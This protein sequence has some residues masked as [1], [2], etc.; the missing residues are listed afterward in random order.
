[1]GQQTS[2]AANPHQFDTPL[3]LDSL[4]ETSLHSEAQRPLPSHWS[5]GRAAG[6]GRVLFWTFLLPNDPTRM[7]SAPVSSAKR[8]NLFG[9]LAWLALWP[10]QP[11]GP[12]G[13][14]HEI[15]KLFASWHH[16]VEALIEAT[17]PAGIVK[18]D[19]R[20]R[21][22]LRRWGDGCVTLLGDAAHP[23]TPNVGH[24]ACM[25]IEDAVCL[26]KAVLKSKKFRRGI[27]GLRGE[28]AIPNCLRRLAGKEH[29]RHRAT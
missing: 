2:M 14:R 20:D 8:F 12:E 7:A 3:A 23:I 10:S 21:R 18:N 16:P 27:S 29:R 1:M 11:S 22:P 6:G 24:G 9:W 13:S 19:A 26:A 5:P 4:S 25:A 17:D 15:Q 28:E